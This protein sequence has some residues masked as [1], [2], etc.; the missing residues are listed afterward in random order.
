VV[1]IFPGRASIIRL[2]GAMLAEQHHEWAEGR[3]HLGLDVLARSQTIGTSQEVTTEPS[4]I[5]A[6]TT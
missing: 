5:T 2:V 6:I 4:T 3:R 1:G